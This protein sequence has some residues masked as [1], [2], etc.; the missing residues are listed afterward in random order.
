M[1]KVAGLTLSVLATGLFVGGV[2]TTP[3][4]AA[5]DAPKNE[6]YDRI[7]KTHKMNWGVKG[8]TKLMGLTDIKTGKLEGFDIDMAKAITKRIDPKAKPELTQITSG[9]RV[10]MLL[11]GNIDAIIATMTITPEREKVVDFSEPYFNAGQALMVKKSSDVKSIK[12]MNHKGARILGVQG[13]NSIENVKKFAP[14]AKVVA[15]PDYATAL[16]A[17]ESGQGDALTTDNSILYGM[18]VDNHNVKVVGGTFTTEPYGVA[19]DKNDPKLTKAINKAI[20]E[21]KADGSYD[22]LAKKWF[23]NVPGMHWKE[24]TE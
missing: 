3:V 14:K 18:A 13:S 23:S 15:L 20:D 5:T 7:K 1:K 6:T 11:N 10:P 17:L 16:T 22:K 4:Q 9:T 19:V 12:D 2:S 8:D 21:M 24:V